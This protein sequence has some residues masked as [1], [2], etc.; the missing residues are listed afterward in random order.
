MHGELMEFNEN[1]HRQILAKE[2]LIKSLQGELTDLRGPV[3][4][5]YYFL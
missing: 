3:S 2:K 1:L 4:I 5:G